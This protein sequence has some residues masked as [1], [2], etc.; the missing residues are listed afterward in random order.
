MPY[1]KIFKT[2]EEIK[3]WEEECD[4]QWEYGKYV[5]YTDVRY[6]YDAKFPLIIDLENGKTE[7]NSNGRDTTYYQAMSI[8]DLME[9]I[10]SISTATA[11]EAE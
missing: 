9:F 3:K 10:A 5:P 8:P 2:E 6:N 11:G 4:S 7:I 1:Y